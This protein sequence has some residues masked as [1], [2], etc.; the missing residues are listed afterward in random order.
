MQKQ[1]L[2]TDRQAHFLDAAAQCQQ[3]NAGFVNNLH[4]FWMALLRKAVPVPAPSFGPLYNEPDCGTDPDVNFFFLI[5]E[6]RWCLL[7]LLKYSY[8]QI[9]IP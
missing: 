1:S 9:L 8:E 3:H 4:G 7:L 6:E 2:N 5:D